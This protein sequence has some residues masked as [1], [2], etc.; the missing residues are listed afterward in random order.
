MRRARECGGDLV[1]VSEVEIEAYISGHVVVENGRAR[2]GRG[3]RRGD[4]RQRLDLD[5]HRLGGVLGLG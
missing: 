3:A 2:R 4:G 5:L 1:A